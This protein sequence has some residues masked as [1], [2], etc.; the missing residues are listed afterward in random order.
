[1]PTKGATKSLTES[2]SAPR[3]RVQSVAR[4]AGILFSVARSEQG[5]SRKELSLVT[6]L[7]PQTTYH[8]LHTLT[9]LGLVVRNM[10][11]KYLLGMRVGTLIE[12]FRRQMGGALNINKAL[13]EIASETGESVYAVKWTDGEIVAFDV[14]RGRQPIQMVDLPV[15]ISE[16]AHARAGGKLLLAHANPET[17]RDYLS[18]HPLRRRTANTICSKR[19]LYK[20]FDEILQKGYA[21]DSEEYLLGLSCVA[22][23]MDD[24]ISP[25]AI[26]IS[27]PS[28]R[29]VRNFSKYLECLRK[30]AARLA[31]APGFSSARH[32]KSSD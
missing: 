3:Y 1:M 7:S 12:G 18:R 22:V 4:A 17:R 20:H 16:D 10:D 15:G 30:G 28:E 32:D 19:E 5:A 25:L 23:P 26:G 2:T 14:A 11:G 21:M 29:I 31:T 24:G 6:D 9:Q 8:L 27:A 13:R